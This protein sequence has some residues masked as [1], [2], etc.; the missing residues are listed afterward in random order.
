[1][2]WSTSRSVVLSAVAASA[3]AACGQG[4]TDPGAGDPSD[5]GPVA[6]DPAAELVAQGVVMQSDPQ[7]RVELCIGPVLT[8]YPP[9]CSGPGLLG[10]FSWDDVQAQEQGGV[11]W[12]DASYI[13]VGTYDRGTD[14]FT[15]IRPLST[16]PPPD[17]EMPTPED[18][19]FPQLCDDPFRA[20]DPAFTEDIGSRERL[21][22]RLE[23]M[24][25]YVAAWVSDGADLF[26]VVVTGD[27]EEAYASLREV[28]PGGLCVVQ[29]DLPTAA[30]I[31]A[32]QAALVDRSDDVGLL[33]SHGGVGGR[34]EVNVVVADVE[35]T[36][37]IHDIV[38]PWLTP[39]EVRLVS[40]LLPLTGDE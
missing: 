15:L 17:F 12:S 27:P 22:Q 34:L 7:A 10:E 4:A 13:A 36:S 18:V 2:R 6:G 25:G 11:R 16:E 8:S 1:M 14:T 31:D 24:E 5:V 20:G 38:S 33:T 30:E 28:W 32:A 29:R 37:L 40:A 19:D 39:D 23:T 3:L 9:Q 26:N 21:Q 35:T